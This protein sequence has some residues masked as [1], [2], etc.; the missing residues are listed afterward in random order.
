MLIKNPQIIHK[1]NGENSPNN[2]QIKAK[3]TIQLD[4]DGKLILN[5]FNN[6]DNLN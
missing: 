1:V 3:I 6:K 5:M 4:E 2:Q